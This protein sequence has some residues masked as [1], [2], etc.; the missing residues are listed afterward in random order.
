MW[1][2]LPVQNLVDLQRMA[3]VERTMQ[4]CAELL[5]Q[6]YAV[7]ADAL[8]DELIERKAQWDSESR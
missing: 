4:K 3:A 1:D 2:R 8:L 7:E 6:G 5:A